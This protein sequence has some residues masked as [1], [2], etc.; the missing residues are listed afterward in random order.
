M[1]RGKRDAERGFSYLE[2]MV[3]T[4]LTMLV[5]LAASG[6]VANALHAAAVVERKTALTDDALNTLADIRAVAGYGD[7]SP[8]DRASQTLPYLFGR[9][10]TH[11][12]ALPGG[13]QE[14]IAI[15]IDARA[16]GARQTYA[17][18]TASAN[19]VSVT[20]RQALSYEAPSPGSS[21]TEP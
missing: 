6:A 10:T 11:I 14:T 1:H 12:V 5:V 18:V 16:P 20:E 3:A 8:A 9:T 7:P 15:A 2:V 17:S 4:V 13:A 19:G 21:V